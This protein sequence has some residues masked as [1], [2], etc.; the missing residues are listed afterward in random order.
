MQRWK[1]NEDI[2]QGDALLGWIILFDAVGL[3]IQTQLAA[4]SGVAATFDGG[5]LPGVTV[6][7]NNMDTGR[8][9]TAVTNADS[10]FRADVPPGRYEIAAA[11]V[12]IVSKD[13]KK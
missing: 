6:T 5:V 8:V 3:T 2:N 12:E 7:L 4:V 9:Q 11:S 13:N 10:E 1:T